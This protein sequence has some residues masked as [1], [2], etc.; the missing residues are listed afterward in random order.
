VTTLEAQ[1]HK[2]SRKITPEAVTRSGA[3]ISRKLRDNDKT[4]RTAY[5]RMFVS[6]VTVS[7]TQ[8]IINGPQSALEV[9]LASGGKKPPSLVPS[10][11]QQWCPWPDSNQHIFRYRILSAARLPISPQGLDAASH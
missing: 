4:L 2:G 6:K 8:I 10:F 1:L 11:D 3:L 9:A 5:T 7:Q